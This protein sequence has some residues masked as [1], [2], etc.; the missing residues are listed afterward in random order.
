MLFVWIIFISIL[1]CQIFIICSYTVLILN[2]L[3]LLEISSYSKYLFR[4]M[5]ILERGLVF[6]NIF[7]VTSCLYGFFRFLQQNRLFS[8]LPKE[9]ANIMEA[10]NTVNVFFEDVSL[11]F[12]F[13]VIEIII[14][15]SAYVCACACTCVYLMSLGRASGADF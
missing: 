2:F 1:Y 4:L 13:F 12:D 15:K 9:K 8:A 10:S 7:L 6:I 11:F 3:V 14:C 5:P